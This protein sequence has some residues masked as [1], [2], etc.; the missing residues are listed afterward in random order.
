MQSKHQTEQAARA[1]AVK[2]GNTKVTVIA[3]QGAFYV[4]TEP[5]MIRGFET[6]VYEGRGRNAMKEAAV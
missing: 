2:Q 5:A 1:A 3:S 6:V 4:E